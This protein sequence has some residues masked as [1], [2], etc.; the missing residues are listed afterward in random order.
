[1]LLDPELRKNLSRGGRRICQ[2]FVGSTWRKKFCQ[3]T[4][5]THQVC[6]NH[7]H[8]HP[9]VPRSLSLCSFLFRFLVLLALLPLL[10]FLLFLLNFL[11]AVC[12]EVI[13][14][15]TKSIILNTKSIIF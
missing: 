13:I 9:S 11:L 10:L 2:V 1:M 8:P 6:A 5:L 12:I 4:A 14:Y 7:A 3:I 15:N